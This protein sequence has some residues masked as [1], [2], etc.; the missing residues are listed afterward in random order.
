M[1]GEATPED[2][3]VGLKSLTQLRL[4]Q[5]EPPP[6]LEA[7]SPKGASSEW[8]PYLGANAFSGLRQAICTRVT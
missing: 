8:F 2:S 1:L 4:S 7:K 3:P 6:P 5:L